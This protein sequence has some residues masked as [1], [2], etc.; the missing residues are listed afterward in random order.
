MILADEADVLE[1]AFFRA[2]VPDI[3]SL[4]FREADLED[5]VQYLAIERDILPD[6][7]RYFT[8]SDETLCEKHRIP[9]ETCGCEATREERVAIYQLNPETLVEE[10]VAAVRD[11]GIFTSLEWEQITSTHHVL[12]ARLDRT[13]IVFQCFFDGGEMKQHDFNIQA[14]EF[15]VSFC[16]DQE[17]VDRDYRYSWREFLDD[18]FQDRLITDI[19]HL[20]EAIGSS[21]YEFTPLEGYRD[22]VRQGLRDYFKASDYEVRSEVGEVCPAE[23]MRYGIDTGSADLVAFNDESHFVICHCEKSQG[24][25]VHHFLD[26]RI[27]SAE[28]TPIIEDMT[29]KIELKINRYQDIREDKQTASRFV[30]VIATFFSIGF[31]VLLLDRLGSITAVLQQQLGLGQGLEVL[32][33][34]LLILDAIAALV[35][36]YVIARP[37]WDDYWFNWDIEPFGGNEVTEAG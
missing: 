30:T 6:I 3:T 1:E 13:K 22:R 18:H 21:F 27:E 2:G 10:W 34:A 23:T 35:L 11:K 29:E 9:I 28:Q 8:V 15:G 7:R 31:V 26:G 32:G 5:Y 36:A 14:L 37:Y 4:E 16:G 24:W 19:K 12:T 20:K 25:H 17:I 33:V